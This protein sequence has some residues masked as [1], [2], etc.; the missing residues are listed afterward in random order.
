MNTAMQELTNGVAGMLGHTVFPAIVKGIKDNKGVD[1]TLEELAKW[2]NLPMNR[3][4]QPAMPFGGA[5]PAPVTTTTSTAGAKKKPGTKVEVKPL[6]N[7]DG[8]FQTSTGKPFIEGKSCKHFYEKGLVNAGKFCGRDVVK[9]TDYCSTKSHKDKENKQKVQPGVAPK[10]EVAQ[11]QEEEDNGGL[12]VKWYDEERE[13]Y[14]EITNS[15]IL[16]AKGTEE[17][18]IYVVYGKLHPDNNIKPL[19]ENEKIIAKALGLTIPD[20]EESKAPVNKPQ[21]PIPIPQATPQIPI[22]MPQAVQQVAPQIPMPIPQATPQMPRVVP[23]FP[24]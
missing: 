16:K 21:I 4:L 20:V 22:P 14:E 5:V 3:S 17:N 9:G 11:P 10:V 19:T 2:S 18:P 8:S 13:L 6:L 1:V 23:Q 12:Q 24:K 15:F 7:P